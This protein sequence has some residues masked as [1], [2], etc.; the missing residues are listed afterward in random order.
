MI[1][2][3]HLILASLLL[4]TAYSCTHKINHE[5]RELANIAE[6]RFEIYDRQGVYQEHPLTKSGSATK[7]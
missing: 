7:Q 2:F 1:R 6:E 5:T 3:Q 4:F